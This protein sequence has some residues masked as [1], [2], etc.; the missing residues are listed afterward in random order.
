M[1]KQ[2]SLQRFIALAAPVLLLPLAFDV[3]YMSAKTSVASNYTPSMLA[4]ALPA[5]MDAPPALLANGSVDDSNRLVILP[6]E[7]PG[8]TGWPRPSQTLA[9]YFRMVHHCNKATEIDAQ[10]KCLMH[11]HHQACK[12]GGSLIYVRAYGP[13]VLSGQVE[14]HRNGTYTVAFRPLDTG[15]YTVEA[16]LTFSNPPPL[17]TFPMSNLTEPTYEGYLLPS[18]P[19]TVT[20]RA[21]ASASAASSVLERNLPPCTTADL[22][23]SSLDSALSTGRWRVQEKVLENP[24]VARPFIADNH[25]LTRQ[26]YEHGLNSLGMRMDYVHRK[27]TLL[28][29]ADVRGSNRL[30]E[31]K[32][33][34]PAF[35]KHIHLVLVGDS[36][37]GMQ[38]DWADKQDTLGHQYK[39]S[40]VMT[41][42]GL[43]AQLNNITAELEK[44][45]HEDAQAGIA[46]HY[47]V[48]FNSG[49]HDIIHVSCL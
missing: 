8:Y 11:C 20:A 12:R 23:E 46:A 2:S 25:G 9:G 45:L 43:L 37:I 47:I 40:I 48:V 30:A 21:S 36:N 7:L 38:A 5:E 44:V 13:A 27:C 33:R 3:Y 18:F 28:S 49:M 15:R 41:H 26:G 42:G 10:W 4:T 34:N 32:Q 29:E 39:G 22:L 14:D 6:G 35:Q 1:K 17:R 24:F 16:V 31:C 19:M